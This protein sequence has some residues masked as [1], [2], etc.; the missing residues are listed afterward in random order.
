MAKF[1]FPFSGE[2][3]VLNV[4]TR[5]GLPGEFIQLPDGV[6]HYELAGPKQG[7]LVVLVHG[8]SVPYFIWNPTFIGLLSVGF[9]V[10]RYDLYGRG[11]SDRPHTRYD[12]ALFDRQLTGLLDALGFDQSV[13]LVGLSMGGLVA[14]NFALAHPERTARLGLIDPAGF[15]LGYSPTFRMLMVPLLGELLFSLAGNANLEQSMASDFYDP[16]HVE[17]FI[18]EYRPQ[19]AFKG[20]KRALLSTMRAGFISDG[21]EF[22][23][24]VGKTDLPVLLVWGR[25]DQTV[26]FRFSQ[27]VVKA[28]PQVQFHPIDGAGHIPHYEKPEVVTP[29]LIEFLKEGRG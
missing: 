9:Q 8:F 22:Y 29:L 14:A 12:L 1:E 4:E 21:V 7:P 20:F 11:F 26:P 24:Q 16:A 27:E 6:V 2:T 23:E 17:A 15:P 19:M 10:L 5:A 25:E 18:D 3:Q 28:I 13:S